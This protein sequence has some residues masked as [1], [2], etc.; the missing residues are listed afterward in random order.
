MR[1]HTRPD[2]VVTREELPSGTITV[3]ART[4]P[5]LSA[6]TEYQP[7]TR[8]VPRPELALRYGRSEKVEEA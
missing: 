3:G 5:T 6:S 8:D 7:G 4:N 2:W 1:D